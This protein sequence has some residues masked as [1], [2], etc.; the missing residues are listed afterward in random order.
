MRY[1]VK[2]ARNKA[3]TRVNRFCTE[4]DAHIKVTKPRRSQCRI[5]KFEK[6]FERDSLY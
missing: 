6:D 1:I 2:K 5:I 3:E 4:S